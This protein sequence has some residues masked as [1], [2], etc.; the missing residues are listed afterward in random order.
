MNKLHITNYTAVNA[1]GYGKEDIKQSLIDGR[2]GLTSCNFKGTRLNTYVGMVNGLDEYVLSDE[3]SEFDCR[4]NRLAYAA[5]QQDSFAKNVKEKINE[6]GANRVAVIIGTSTSGIEELEISY[7]SRDPRNGALPRHKKSRYTYNLYSVS[8]FIRDYLG[9]SGPC[10]TISTACSSS[11]KVFATAARL[12]ES[13]FCDA[14]VVGGVDSLCLNTLY[15]FDSLQILSDVPCRPFAS[16][17]NGI[18]I[19]EGGGLALLEK[20][21]IATSSL[22]LKGY[23]ESTDAYHMSTP[24]PDGSGA[25]KAMRQALAYS[26]LELGQIDY[27]NL[28]GTGSKVNDQSEN[29]AIL[30]VFGAPVRVTATK[31]FTGHTLGAAG[32]TEAIISFLSIEH[33]FLPATI[34][35]RELDSDID[36]DVQLQGQDMHVDNVMSNS[37]GFGGNNCSLI[38]GKV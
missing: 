32:I 1:L 7:R 17:R 6:Y 23:G 11:A 13:G 9:A 24:P 4:N 37:F 21:A 2:T 30:S 35:T 22:A 29:N 38:F 28:H 8:D 19:G 36:V 3:F 25:I 16:D 27:I 10:Y 12:I 31:G 14:A 26:N 18:S 33:Q 34:N 5:M 15:G 20:N